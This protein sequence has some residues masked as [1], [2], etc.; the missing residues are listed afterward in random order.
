MAS[1]IRRIRDVKMKA[2]GGLCYF[3]NGRCG[4]PTRTRSTAFNVSPGL[5]KMLRCTAEHLTPRSEGGKNGGDDIVAAC[6]C[7]QTRHRARRPRRPDAYGS[8]SGAA[9]P[10]GAGCRSGR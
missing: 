7:N 5:A 6:R 1:T 8:W 9:S 10:R 4:S 2:Q 3:A